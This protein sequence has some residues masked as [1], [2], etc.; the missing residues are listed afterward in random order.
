MGPP[1]NK[2]PAA[3][4]KRRALRGPALQEMHPGGGTAHLPLREKVLAAVGA[5]TIEISHLE[6]K[7]DSWG[8]RGALRAAAHLP[9]CPFLS[10]N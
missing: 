8:E 1:G 4:G 10:C 2:E 9:P 7:P 5:V 3:A 6:R